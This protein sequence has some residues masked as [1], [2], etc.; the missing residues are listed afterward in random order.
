MTTV[1][2]PT[3]AGPSFDDAYAFFSPDAR[4]LRAQ[5]FVVGPS[6]GSQTHVSMRSTEMRQQP[7]AQWLRQIDM[8][9]KL[10]RDWDS[11]GAEPINALAIAKARALLTDLSL[12]SLAAAYVPFHMAPDPSGGIQIEW[13]PADGAGALEIWIGSDGS[14]E[15][16]IDR[17]FSEPRFSERALARIS[18]AV[19]EIK[20]FAA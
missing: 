19:S 8:F 4:K 5:V 17:P 1:A 14:M 9:A 20:T 16:I 11:Y 13:R 6:P 18:A 15:S 10:S 7:F 3:Y 2:L 12:Q